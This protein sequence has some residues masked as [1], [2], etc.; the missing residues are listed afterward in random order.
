MIIIRTKLKERGLPRKNINIRHPDGDL[1]RAV[2]RQAR[3]MKPNTHDI[4]GQFLGFWREKRPRRY[5]FRQTAGRIL[6]I[7]ILFIEDNGVI[8][9]LH[10]LEIFINIS[11]PHTCHDDLFFVNKRRFIR[12][13]HII[14]TCELFNIT[15]IDTIAP[16]NRAIR[17]P[18]AVTLEEGATLE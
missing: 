12:N 17:F 1:T 3:L 16:I 15:P 6:R 8:V 5:Y 13:Y 18:Q 14:N 4:I 11:H 2:F 7:N 10:L 9:F